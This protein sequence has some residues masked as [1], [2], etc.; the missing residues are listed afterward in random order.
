MKSAGTASYAT[1]QVTKELLD[2]ADKIY[3][4]EQNHYTNIRKIS[5]NCFSITRVLGIEDRYQ[6]NS[7]KLVVTLLSKMIQ[8][9]PLDDW[10]Q[11]KFNLER[12]Q[13]EA[14]ND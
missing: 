13:D 5:P 1:V 12:N 4:M 14:H 3:V 11:Q 9:E 10:L 7:A 8:I 2:W 6:T